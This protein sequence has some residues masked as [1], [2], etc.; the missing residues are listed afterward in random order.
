MTKLRVL[1]F[2]ITFLIVAGAGTASI[3]YAR[4]Y[5]LGMIQKKV[6]L[7]P[8]GILVVNSDPNGA[9]VF[10]NGEFETATNNTISLTPATYDV[11]I[12]KDGF[13]SWEKRIKIEKETVTQVDAFLIASAPSLTALTFSGVFNPKP[14]SDFSK[15]AYGILPNSD[16]GERA[17]L[18]VLET[19]NLPLGFNRDPRQITD[20]D[21]RNAKWEW[22]PDGREILLSSNTGIFLLDTQKY[23]VQNQRVNVASQIATIKEE[24]DKKAEKKLN[25]QLSQLDDQIEKIFIQNAV[26]IKFSP[27]EN[28]ILYT[29]S[30]SATIPDDIVKSLPGASTQ[31]QERDIKDGKSYVYDIKEDRNF[32]TGDKGENLYWLP[33]SLNLIMP[34]E[35]KI[36]IM[37]YD[38]TNNQSVFGGGYEFPHAYPSTNSNRVMILTKFG[39]E[40]TLPNLYWLSLK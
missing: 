37:D 24:W 11:Q 22:S 26:D 23:T 3:L 8:R 15:I 20:G 40:D 9:Q 4:G 13:L 10:I 25:S 18:W 17:G 30:G 39:G 7:I 16:N 38:G 32:A 19:V 34:K 35:D 6:S 28:R 21:L 5:R 27:D 31:Q 36:M 33:N 1:V 14:T 2:L 29:A 12:R